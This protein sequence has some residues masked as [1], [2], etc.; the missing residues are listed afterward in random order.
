MNGS[1]IQDLDLK[2]VPSMRRNEIISDIFGRLHY[3]DRRGSG[4]RRIINSYT[5]YENKPSFYSNEYF[6]LVSLPNRGIASRIKHTTGKTQL[7]TEKTQLTAEKTQLEVLRADI[8]QKTE[9]IFRPVTV[10]KIIKLLSTYE[11]K[12]SFNRQIVAKQFEISENAASRILK[13]A[14]DC[15]IVRKEKKEFIISNNSCTMNKLPYTFSVIFF[16]IIS[17]SATYIGLA[18]FYLGLWGRRL[19]APQFAAGRPQS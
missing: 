13:K 12:Y 19:T 10:D 8:R 4:I 18:Y 14:M 15:G 11:N 17:I 2:T 5:H 9:K 1:R 3:M 6:F 7:T 16:G